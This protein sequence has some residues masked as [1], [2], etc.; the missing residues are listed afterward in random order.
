MARTGSVVARRDSTIALM[1]WATSTLGRLPSTISQSSLG[2]RAAPIAISD[3]G[4]RRL[5]GRVAR[6][7]TR[8]IMAGAPTTDRNA[9]AP[10]GPLGGPKMAWLHT[11]GDNSPFGET[12]SIS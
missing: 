3:R 1:V 2:G 4:K 9:M 12:R 11:T 8:M 10:V 5:A 7:L 6:G